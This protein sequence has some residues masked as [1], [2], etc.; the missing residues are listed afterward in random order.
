MLRFKKMNAENNEQLARAKRGGDNHTSCF[1]L[2]NRIRNLNNKVNIDF[3]IFRG[4]LVSGKNFQ[5]FHC[6]FKEGFDELNCLKDGN[7]SKEEE[8]AQELILDSL[9]L[10]YVDSQANMDKN[11]RRSIDQDELN[12]LRNNYVH[13]LI[14]IQDLNGIVCHQE[15]SLY[16]NFKLTKNPVSTFKPNELF[17][18]IPKF[19]ATIWNMNSPQII[20][21]IIT[22]VSN[23]KNWKNQKLEEQFKK[24]IIKAANKT[25]MW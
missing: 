19:M 4:L 25:E 7:K 23:F 13:G 18:N 20:I 16:L 21:P 2:Y 9:S 3:R 17:K 24:G 1:Q 22:G 5:S 8:T 10:K 6:C 15:G 11:T 14:R 12:Q